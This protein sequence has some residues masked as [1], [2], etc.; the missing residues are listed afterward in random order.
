[1]QTD[2]NVPEGHAGL[3]QELYGGAGGADDAHAAVEDAGLADASEG[4]LRGNALFPLSEWLTKREGQKPCGL[5]AIYDRD[6]KLKFVGY[7]RNIVLAI[8]GYVETAGDSSGEAEDLFCRIKLFQARKLKSRAHLQR[9]RDVWLAELAAKGGGEDIAAE[10]KEIFDRLASKAIA[11]TEE[12][13]ARHE[14]QKLKMRKAMGE[15][16]LDDEEG[17]EDL[18]AAARQRQRRLDTI[19]AVEGDDW[20]EVIDKQTRE[21]LISQGNGRQEEETREQE[22][23]EDVAKPASAKGE[24]KRVV[25]RS[26]FATRDS[27]AEAAARARGSGGSHGGGGGPGGSPLVMDVDSVNLVLDEVRPYL[28]AD[29]GNVQVVAVEGGVVKLKLEGACGTCA[30]ATATMSMGLERALRNHF[31]GLVKEV[32]RVGDAS[33]VG[34]GGSGD[35]TAEAVDS[36]L[37]MLRPAIEGYGG[38]VLVKSVESNYRCT[39]QYKGPPPLAKGIQAAIRDRFPTMSQIE[40]EMLP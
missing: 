19:K 5:Y 1:V 11:R 24:G 40:I 4:E 28:I 12:E 20:S 10:E 31:G 23:S 26:P 36:H 8:R 38:K 27:E 18:D 35:I 22:K 30:S 3:H 29:G 37:N 21:T 7:S 39:V 13:A 32:V 25:T 16:L 2:D 34:A 6:E 14:E 17:E 9:E 15:A 33:A